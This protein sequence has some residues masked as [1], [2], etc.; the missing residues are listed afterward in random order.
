MV[1]GRYSERDEAR[2]FE[3]AIDA[4]TGKEERAD[5]LEELRQHLQ[6]KANI[7]TS[8]TDGQLQILSNF[9][10]TQLQHYR[11]EAK[12]RT[13]WDALAGPSQEP[14]ELAWEDTQAMMG[15]LLGLGAQEL[16]MSNRS[17]AQISQKLEQSQIDAQQRDRIVQTLRALGGGSEPSD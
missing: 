7:S 14:R 6:Y 13:L 16:A 1:E 11:E 10:L 5:A 8:L 15:A 4:L 12:P 3:K 9:Y 17:I 2:I